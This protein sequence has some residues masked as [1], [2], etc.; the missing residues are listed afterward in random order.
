MNLQILKDNLGNQTGV[1]VP[2]EDWK[3]IKTNYPD[4]ETIDSDLSQAE[5]DF[6][7]ARLDIANKYPERLNPI[8]ELFYELN[9]KI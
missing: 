2:M 5:K 4:I 8:N 1:F 6:I 3:I 9:K 7:D